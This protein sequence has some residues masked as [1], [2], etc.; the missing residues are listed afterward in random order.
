LS[1]VF[2]YHPVFGTRKEKGD[3]SLCGR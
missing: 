1:A 2:S 3:E